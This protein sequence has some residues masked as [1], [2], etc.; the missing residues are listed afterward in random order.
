MHTWLKK[1]FVKI[2]DVG[3]GNHSPSRTKKY[4]PQ[5]KYY[6]VD[7]I[8]NYN[9]NAIDF[10]CMEYFYEAD[11]ANSSTFDSIPDNFF[12]CII[13]SHVIEHLHKGEEVIVHLLKKLNSS[14]VIYLEWPSEKSVTLPSMKGTLNFYD[15]TTHV[16]LY[17]IESLAALFTEHELS[18]VASG[19]RRSLKR[20]VLLPLYAIVSLLHEGFLGGHVFW[21]IAGF[22]NYIIAKKSYGMPPSTVIKTG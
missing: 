17:Q 5:C 7:K 16:R 2:L 4:Y 21:D 1:P 18:I 13:L 19:T 12:D 14:G 3:C 22:A 6:G 8:R 9:N 11:L 20:I 15:D 10:Q